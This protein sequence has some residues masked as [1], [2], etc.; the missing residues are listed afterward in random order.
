[1][2]ALAAGSGVTLTVAATD[3]ILIDCPSGGTA[4]IEAVSGVA[5]ASFSKILVEHRGGRAQYGPFGAGDIKLGALGAELRYDYGSNPKIYDPY[6]ALISTDSSGNVT[7]LVGPDGSL[8]FMYTPQSKLQLLAPKP[9]GFNYYSLVYEILQSV[10]NIATNR[11]LQLAYIRDAGGNMVRIGLPCFS[12]AQYLSLVHSTVSMPTTVSD[13]NLRSTYIAALDTAFDAAASYGLK[14]HISDSW[15]QSYLPIALGETLATG[16][17]NTTTKTA[18]YMKSAAEWLFRRYANHAAFGVYSIGNEWQTDDTGTTKPTP[19]QLGAFFTFIAS[20]CRVIDPSK[21]VTADLVP[22]GQVATKSR[23]LPEVAAV[24]YGLLYAGLDA[25]CL[26]FFSD[27]YDYVGRNENETAAYPNAYTNTLGFEGM[28]SLVECY[29]AMASAQGKPLL[30]GE[31]G[32]S[33]SHEADGTFTKKRRVMKAAS[34][35]CEYSLWW[36]VQDSVQAVPPQDVWFIA[37]STTRGDTFTALALEANNSRMPKLRIAGGTKALRAQIRPSTCM[38]STRTAGAICSVPAVAFQSATNYALLFWVRLNSTLNSYEAFVDFRGASNFNGL[39]ALGDSTAATNYYV[40]FRAAAGGAGNNAA[41]LPDP[42]LGDWHHVAVMYG[43]VIGANT[44]TT[45]LNGL[46]WKTLAATG[47][48]GAIPNP[49]TIEFLGSTSGAP[50]SMQDIALCPYVSAEDVYAHMRG[51][52]L[53]QS[54]L[55]I[56]ALPNGTI[57]DIGPSALAVTVGAGVTVES[58]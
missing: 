42:A 12:S 21:I 41:Q 23:I 1:M 36:N 15:N 54:L 56:R 44:I 20:A 34:T 32:V 17:I 49:T 46:Y 27:D 55:H 14:L 33:T 6:P 16:Y 30:C 10:A 53:R 48:L 50:V 28:M 40:E 39:V 58:L 22:P 31:L 25:W 45:W 9:M 38:T 24:R 7:G 57:V 8:P 3:V 43:P 13:S 19:A 11:P 5:G 26:H 47:T 18:V 35:F 29:S 37:P 2:T 4:K 51:E 52:Y